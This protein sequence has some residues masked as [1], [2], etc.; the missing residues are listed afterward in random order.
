[1]LHDRSMKRMDDENTKIGI[2]WR[3]EIALLIEEQDIRFSEIV[4]ENFWSCKHLPIALQNLIERGATVIPH[5][6]SLSLGSAVTP[7]L[8]RIERLAKLA[9]QTR[10]PFVSEHIALVRGGGYETGHLLPVERTE[11]MT[12]III[13]NVRIA[14]RN[15]PVPLVLENIATLIDFA[16]SAE[17]SEA[18]FVTRIVNE[19]GAGILLDVSNLY[20]N[21]FNHG[22]NYKEYIATIPLQKIQYVHIAGGVH[23]NKMYHDTHAHALHSRPLEVLSE[24]CKVSPPPAVLLERDDRF[25]SPAEL[26]AELALIREVVDRKPVHA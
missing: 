4:A 19:T 18:E 26:L 24:L 23:R 20:A 6:V 12:E 11:E 5:G 22:V 15:L 13:E 7:D 16:D 1:M 17:M 9:A 8:W 3:P 2:G 10:A 14:Q 21:C 25:G